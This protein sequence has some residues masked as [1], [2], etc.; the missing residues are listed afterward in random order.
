MTPMVASEWERLLAS[1]PD[2]AYSAYLVR[3]LR[4][5]FHIG[6]SYGSVRCRSAVSNMQSAGERPSVIDTFLATELAAER[7]L[8]PVDPG[9]AGS[10]QVNRFGL[11]PKGHE[12]DNWRLIVDLSFP[13]ASSVNDG[14]GPE[15]CGLR[16]T[17]VD[18]A[19]Q[20]V[21]ELGQGAV[22]AKF[23]MSGAFR[24]VPVHPDDRHLLG[25]WWWGHTYV[26]KVLPYG[27]RSA[28]KLYNV[29]ADG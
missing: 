15:L 1:H 25:M 11:V 9:L 12:P 13:G 10:I 29:V 8:G 26:D 23:D 2:D 5:G 21:L 7:V 22:L 27:L 24:T 3:G 19:C 6:F 16:Y 17:S 4:D 18:A 14:I 20:R 28:P